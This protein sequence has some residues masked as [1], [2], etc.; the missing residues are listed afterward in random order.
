MGIDEKEYCEYCG[1]E[2]DAD[3]FGINDACQM[4]KAD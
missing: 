1:T 3:G 2:I 4:C